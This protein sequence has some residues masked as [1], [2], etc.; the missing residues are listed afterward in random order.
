MKLIEVLSNNARPD[1]I[2]FSFRD[3]DC[4]C[5]YTETNGST[6]FL[7]VVSAEVVADLDKRYERG[8]FF[9]SMALDLMDA[10]IDDKDIWRVISESEFLNL[11]DEP[12]DSDDWL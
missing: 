11:L 4:M 6:D 10:Y 3:D 2:K 1:N 7:C 12:D 9:W 8:T 5:I